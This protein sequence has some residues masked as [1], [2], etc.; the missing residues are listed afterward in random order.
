MPVS[1]ITGAFDS[2]WSPSRKLPK[3][4]ALVFN[5]HTTLWWLIHHTPISEECLVKLKAWQCFQTN[6]IFP[7]RYDKSLSESGFHC[8]SSF[9]NQLNQIN[10]TGNYVFNKDN[11]ASVSSM[12][13]IFLCGDNK[14]PVLSIEESICITLH[15]TSI[16][17][18][19]KCLAG[20]QDW[21]ATH[22]SWSRLSNDYGVV[23]LTCTFVT[24]PLSETQ[25]WLAPWCSDR[26]FHCSSLLL[27]WM[28]AENVNA[29]SHLCIFSFYSLS[30]LNCRN[31]I[32][33][34]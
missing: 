9:R 18:E 14:V 5:W 21:E 30:F 32:N 13:E 6:S 20:C 10:L 22:V 31:I 8:V 16:S 15:E 12:R 28:R 4:L 24:V 26:S 17:W 25:F 27:M 1:A 3:I 7:F 19:G 33:S 2:D 11:S 29:R 23:T 34:S